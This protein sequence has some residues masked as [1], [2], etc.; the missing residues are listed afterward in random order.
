MM[1]EYGLGFWQCKLRYATQAEVV[2]IAR[3]HKERNIP[4]DV[5][6]IDYYHYRA[7]VIFALMK[8]SFQTPRR[9]QKKYEI[10]MESS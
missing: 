3:E 8:I 6:V 4:V 9:W 10:N 1:P 7:V 2:A 5:L